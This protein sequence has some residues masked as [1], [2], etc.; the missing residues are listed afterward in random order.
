VGKRGRPSREQ[1]REIS[2]DILEAALQVFLEHGFGATSMKRVSEAAGVAPNTLYAR[3]SDKESLFE[4]I[5]DW[6]VETWKI[7]NP[8]RYA[9]KGSDL[10][11]VLKVAVAAL[12]EA[13]GREISAGSVS[14][15]WCN[16]IAF[17]N[18]RR[19]I[20]KPPRYSDSRA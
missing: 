13:M 1:E 16:H 17:R 7:T 18:W 15:C 5:I 3:F 2:S 19:S 8:P 4:A 20:T 11:S 10:R 9:P 12:I 14:C 6:K